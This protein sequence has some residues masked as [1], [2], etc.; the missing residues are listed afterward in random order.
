MRKD[1]STISV[2][3]MKPWYKSKT[4]WATI[5]IIILGIFESFGYPINDKVYT[6][7]LA[8]AIYGM[9]VSKKDIHF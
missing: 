3:G 2:R 8:I 9:R 4:I 5:A 7:L 1:D 6:S